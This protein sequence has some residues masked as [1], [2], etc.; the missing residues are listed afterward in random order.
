MK[1]PAAPPGARPSCV[2]PPR[3]RRR[4]GLE[5]ACYWEIELRSQESPPAVEQHH[6]DRLQD[7]R[8]AKAFRVPGAQAAA[9]PSRLTPTITDATSYNYDI[10]GVHGDTAHIA[11]VFDDTDVWA[12]DPLDSRFLYFPS[13]AASASITGGLGSHYVQLNT[14][15]PAAIDS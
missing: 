7:D 10:L 13:V 2:R 12:A 15:T 14:S 9:G 1:G 4:A 3:I 6:L 11:I 8:G 5:P